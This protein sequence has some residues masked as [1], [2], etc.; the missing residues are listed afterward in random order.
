MMDHRCGIGVKST[1]RGGDSGKKGSET[2]LTLA[3]PEA[4][5]RRRLVWAERQWR[6]RSRG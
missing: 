1:T 6:R 3:S 4:D 5:P 2:E